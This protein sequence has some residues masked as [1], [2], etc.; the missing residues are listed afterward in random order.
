MPK[1]YLIKQN[2]LCFAALPTT[3]TI[4]WTCG[5]PYNLCFSCLLVTGGIK[6]KVSWEKLENEKMSNSQ[7]GKKQNLTLTKQKIET[8]V[9]SIH[10]L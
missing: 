1:K 2:K 8:Q 3:M 4:M 10:H 9:L 5:V 6:N 7:S